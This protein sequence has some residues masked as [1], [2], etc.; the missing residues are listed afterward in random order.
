MSFLENL[1]SILH[2][3]VSLAAVSHTYVFHE[4]MNVCKKSSDSLKACFENVNISDMNK[5][6]S[7]QSAH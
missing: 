2:D 4:V 1:I 6:I 3:L 7:V 5:V